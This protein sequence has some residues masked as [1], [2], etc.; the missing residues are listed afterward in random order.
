MPNFY[1]RVDEA[2]HDDQLRRAVDITTRRFV[3]GRLQAMGSLP[4]AEAKRDHARQIRAHT[5]ANL[6]T[7]LAQFAEAIENKG[8]HIYWAATATE[9]TQYVAELA[10]Q[11]G[12]RLAVKSKSMV[13]EE[14]ELNHALEEIEI[15]VVETDLGEFI[16]QLAGEKP[17][18]LIAPATHKSRRE[19]A[20]LFRE[21]LNAAEADLVDVPN[22]TALARRTLRHKFLQADMGITGAN[23]GVAETGTICLVT[24]EGNGRLTSS[25]PPLHVVMMGIERLVPTV[26]DLG[27]MVQLLTRSATGQ[28]ASVYTSL[29]NAPRSNEPDGPTELHVVLVDNGRSEILGSELAEILYCIRC[30]A[31]LNVCPVYRQIGGHAYGSV[32]SGPIGSVVTPGLYGIEPWSELPHAS[33]LCAACREACPMRIDLPRLLLLLRDRSVRANTAPAWLKWGLKAY[34]L[35]VTR[36]GLFR[37]GGRLSS[38][39]TNQMARRGWISN[40]PGPL[41]AWTD[42]RDFPA[43]AKKS[44]SQRWREERS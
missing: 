10:Q 13:S 44:F 28:K 29:I 1:Q 26:Q 12:V 21:K 43:F 5:I 31:C 6:D 3:E 18:H 7:Y 42:H 17:S 8:G 15:E 22:M 9:A 34:R 33:S 41:A 38:W 39:A 16:I 25:L 36:P 30:G 24:N 19:V 27:L 40:L 35:A 37:L 20:V 2:L 4:Q 11:R 23:F 14:V 32:Y